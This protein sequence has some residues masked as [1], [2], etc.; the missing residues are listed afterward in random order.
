MIR[1]NTVVGPAPS[2]AATTSYRC[3]AV[4]SAPSSDTTRNG[5]AT[6]VCAIT[7]AI[8]ENAIWIPSAS[9][10]E[11]SRPRRPNV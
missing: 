8:V 7:T 10:S 11:P 1:R 9:S 5:I 2:D 6:K 3:P 4:R